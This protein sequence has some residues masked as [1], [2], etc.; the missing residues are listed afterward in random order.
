[1]TASL[2]GVQKGSLVHRFITAG[3]PGKCELCTHDAEKL[4]AHH[5]SYEP[6][7]TLNLCHA[8]HLRVYFWPNRLNNL[9]KLKLLSLRFDKRTAHEL[10]DKNNLGLS[11]L[12]KLV[13]PSRSTFV[14]S[15]QSLEIKRICP[16]QKLNHN[17]V[18][19]VNIPLNSAYERGGSLHRILPPSV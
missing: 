11:A 12:A 3:K 6:E 16:R 13:A 10:V 9:E 17:K 1:M 14:R 19:K 8:Y 5:V 7:K 4:E 2:Q 18:F 15:K